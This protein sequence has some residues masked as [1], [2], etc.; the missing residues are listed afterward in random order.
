MA[1]QTI[2]LDGKHYAVLVTRY[3]PV[4]QPS[5]SVAVGLTG[6]TFSQTF[7][8]TRYSWGFD[9]KVYHT[10][11]PGMDERGTLADLKAAAAKSHVDFTNHYGQTYQVY[12]LGG[13]QERPASPA[14]D[15]D[16]AWFTVPVNLL[17]R[18]V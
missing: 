6:K 12:I 1:N 2:I 11:P 10:N 9:L 18:E 8:Y 16:L 5:R 14:V 4:M 17:K 13:I 7:T 15:G 3:E